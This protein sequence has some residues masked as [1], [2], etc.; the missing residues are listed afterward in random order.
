[1]PFH[2]IS[3]LSSAA[4]MSRDLVRKGGI[5]KTSWFSCESIRAAATLVEWAERVDSCNCSESEM[6]GKLQLQRYGIYRACGIPQVDDLSRY[7]V[8]LTITKLQ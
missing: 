3:N 8:K 7:S 2:Q 1:M 6:L 4:D 5:W